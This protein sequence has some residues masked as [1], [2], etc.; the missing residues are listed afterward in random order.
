M[1]AFAPGFGP[2]GV[3]PFAVGRFE[4]MIPLIRHHSQTLFSDVEPF[5]LEMLVNEIVAN[6]FDI[7]TRLAE[8]G[9][10]DLAYPKPLAMAA[11][12]QMRHAGSSC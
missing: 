6:A 3:S 4:Q 12:A 11:L 7:F 1:V 9:L 5:Q 2:K 8:R 10:G